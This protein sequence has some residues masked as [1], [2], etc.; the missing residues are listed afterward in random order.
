MSYSDNLDVYVQ[1]IIGQPEEA[2]KPVHLHPSTPSTQSRK[3]KLRD[4]TEEQKKCCQNECLTRILSDQDITE[5]REKFF[6]K[7]LKKQGKWLMNF[8]EI[9]QRVE[10]G[11]PTFD[12]FVKHKK[13]CQ[14]AWLLSYGISNGRY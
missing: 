4:I 9:S 8:F 10:N 5:T 11:R 3:R 7:T 1:D 6:K 2:R 13:V 12:Y 14:K